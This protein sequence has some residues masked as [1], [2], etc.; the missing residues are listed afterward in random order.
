MGREDWSFKNRAGRPIPHQSPPPPSQVPGRPL[1]GRGAKGGQGSR[2]SV[3][4]AG[5]CR[6]GFR[7][8]PPGPPRTGLGAVHGT[9]ARVPRPGR[10]QPPSRPA[11]SPLVVGGE[12]AAARRVVAILGLPGAGRAA[13]VFVVGRG[14]RHRA[15]GQRASLGRT[16]R[17]RDA[18]GTE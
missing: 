15:A 9:A 6:A 8:A 7:S 16:R 12:N 4:T 17:R 18:A 10:A 2:G 11:P 3:S 13:F 5:G 14:G 1:A